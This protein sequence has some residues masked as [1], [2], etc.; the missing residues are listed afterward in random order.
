MS[1]GA[2][3]SPTNRQAPAGAPEA[4]DARTRDAALMAAYAAGDA[5]AARALIEAYGPGALA[6]ARRML[7]D[8]AQAEEV[9]QEAM[10]RLWR[11]APEWRAGEARVS[12]WLYRVVANLCTDRLRRAR[13]VPLPEGWDPPD[14]GATPPD[15]RLIAA[16]RAEALEAALARLPERQRL[17]VVLRHLE[18]RANPEIAAIMGLSVDAV[19]SLQARG[20]RR[21][22]AIL[23]T[24][25][26]PRT[27][28]EGQA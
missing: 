24:E 12:T 2:G 21:L 16:A 8:A 22:K 19:E 5:G 10:L 4:E 11:V 28:T 20:R 23:G 14:D 13:T 18:D 17:A 27:E 15:A 26:G 1:R 9:V 7:G 25:W 6:L 3:P